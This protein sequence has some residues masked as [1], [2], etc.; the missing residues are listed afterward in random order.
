MAFLTFEEKKK[1]YK[2]QRK[3]NLMPVNAVMETIKK[4]IGLDEDFFTVIKVWDKE[5]GAQ[6]M[7]L[8]GFKNGIIYAQTTFSASIND[9]LLRKKEIINKLNQYLGGKKIKNIKVEI[10]K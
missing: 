1:S 4:Q 2:T 6:N 9:M 10:K 8:C 7:E 5:I 3:S